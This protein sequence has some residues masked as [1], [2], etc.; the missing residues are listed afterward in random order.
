MPIREVPRVVRRLVDVLSV[1]GEHLLVLSPVRTLPRVRARRRRRVQQLP[2]YLALQIANQLQGTFD[3]VQSEED[4]LVGAGV[5]GS[6]LRRDAEFLAVAEQPL[7]APVEGQDGVLRI[8]DERH[9]LGVYAVQGHHA[10]VHRLARERRPVVGQRGVGLQR[11][12]RPEG[13]REVAQRGRVIAQ[14]LGVEPVRAQFE[15]QRLHNRGSVPPEREVDLDG[16]ADALFLDRGEVAV[17]EDARLRLQ[18]PTYRVDCQ[19]REAVPLSL[20]QVVQALA[21]QL[22]AGGRGTAVGELD[23]LQR[24]LLVADGDRPKRDRVRAH[25]EPPDVGRER[26]RLTVEHH[27]LAPPHVQDEGKDVRAHREV[28]VRKPDKLELTGRDGGRLRV[29][30]EDLVVLHP[31][32]VV[33]GH[34]Q[35]LLLHGGHVS[36][37]VF[38]VVIFRRLTHRHTLAAVPRRNLVVPQRHVAQLQ[39]ARSLQLK[40][41]RHVR[42]VGQ[43]QVD[44]GWLVSVGR[45]AEV[46]LVAAQFREELS[47]LVEAQGGLEAAVDIARPPPLALVEVVHLTVRPQHAHRLRHGRFLPHVADLHQR[48]L[49][50]RPHR[51]THL[52]QVLGFSRRTRG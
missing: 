23:H 26:V 37:F 13:R 49:S 25:R 3:A 46:E 42:R 12:R 41:H 47:P 32:V 14:F 28:L 48:G 2:A 27:R 38:P 51:E 16:A 7:R 39:V 29:H 35:P 31:L 8:V 30:I 21:V 43:H 11:Q 10:E 36:I 5:E 18:H 50:V 17:E 9:N 6:R 44:H 15:V 34:D 22:P 20:L 24:A 4:D 19:Q 40:F 33:L 45:G 52:Q 1:G